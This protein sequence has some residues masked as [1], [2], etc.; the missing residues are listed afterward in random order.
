MRAHRTRRDIVL[1]L[2]RANGNGCVGRASWP[3]GRADCRNA[4]PDRGGELPRNAETAANGDVAGPA[5]RGG[6]KI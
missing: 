3:A 1:P 2:K 5:P 6:A 4:A